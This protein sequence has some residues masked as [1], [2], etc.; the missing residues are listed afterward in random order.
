MDYAVIFY[1]TPNTKKKKIGSENIEFNS[2]YYKIISKIIN[3]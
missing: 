2:I 3:E 1:F